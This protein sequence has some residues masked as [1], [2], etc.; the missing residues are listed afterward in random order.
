MY[1]PFKVGQVYW[2]LID[3]FEI[4]DEPGEP[5]WKLASWRCI[6]ETKDKVQA[7]HIKTGKLIEFRKPWPVF[8][9][10]WDAVDD[11]VLALNK[12]SMAVQAKYQEVAKQ[13]ADRL[14]RIEAEKKVLAEFRETI[15]ID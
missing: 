13:A 4:P 14:E 2:K 5:R 8:V 7:V 10:P 9:S 15:S 1:A 11:A 6:G 12:E 3:G